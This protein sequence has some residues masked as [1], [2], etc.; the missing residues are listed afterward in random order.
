MN[1]KIKEIKLKDKIKLNII[2]KVIR[3]THVTH[4]NV[5][6][7]RMDLR[8]GT[9]NYFFRRFVWHNESKIY[10]F[11]L[12]LLQ[13]SNSST[14]FNFSIIH[15][16]STLPA[17]CGAIFCPVTGFYLTFSFLRIRRCKRH[18]FRYQNCFG[19]R[20]VDLRHISPLGVFER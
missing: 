19:S 20:Q 15:H 14:N 10:N 8:G 16:K 13:T 9:K 2:Q 17:I 11:L 1:S 6:L 7:S 4:T 3:G 12:H 5:T 18:S